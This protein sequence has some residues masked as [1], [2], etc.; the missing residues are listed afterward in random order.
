[1][2]F[3]NERNTQKLFILS[4]LLLVLSALSGFSI[5]EPLDSSR[6]GV[7]STDDGE[8]IAYSVTGNSDTAMILVHGWS[9]DSRLWQNQIDFFS[10][11]YKVVTLDLAGHGNSSL[12][13]KEYTMSA[14]ANDIKAVMKKENI[15]NAILVGHSMGGGVIAEAAKLM[16]REVIGIIGVDT[17][18]NVAAPLTQAD[19][20]MMIKPFEEDFQTGMT[21][22]VKNAFP[23]DVDPV[24]LE[25]ATED[26]ASASKGIALNQFRHYLGQYITGESY[27]VFESINVPVV[28]VNARLWPTDS[29]ANKK[30]IKNYSIYFIE[31]SGHFPMLEQPESFNQLL[32]KAAQSIQ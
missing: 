20:N 1:M 27:R 11:Q 3:K 16:P 4:T 30:H 12:N 17:S 9:L 18:Q 23:A 25:W 21:E 24:I 31:D 2:N 19:L 6:Y 13:R 22:F 5:A 10:S 15:D 29:K 8:K 32:L 14:F 28:L 26:M 7:A